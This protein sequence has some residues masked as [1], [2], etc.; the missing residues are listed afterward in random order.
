MWTKPVPANSTW[1]SVRDR[2]HQHTQCY[3]HTHTHTHMLIHFPSSHTHYTHFP[4]SH[5]HHHKRRSLLKNHTTLTSARDVFYSFLFFGHQE[6]APSECPSMSV[7]KILKNCTKIGCHLDPSNNIQ[8]WTRREANVSHPL[9]HLHARPCPGFQLS[10][11][12]TIVD[13][14]LLVRAPSPRSATW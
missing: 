13:R 1:K 7:C 12:R 10:R 6:S 3:T 2:T 11:P 14:L 5:T 8:Y 4:S 9:A